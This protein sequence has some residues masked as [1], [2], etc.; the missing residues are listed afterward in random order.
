MCGPRA[1]PVRVPLSLL[2]EGS[3]KASYLR[4]ERA[5]GDAA[6]TETGAARRTDVL[7]IEMRGGGFVGRGAR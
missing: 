5:R 3:C 4:D 1:W 6:A 2:G 7:T